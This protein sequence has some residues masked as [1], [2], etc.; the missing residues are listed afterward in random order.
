M[1]KNY[2]AG[3]F[4]K[5]H[6]GRSR[7]WLR[8]GPKFFWLIFANSTQ[9]SRVNKV[10]PYWPGSRACLRA[11]EALGFFITKYAF[12]TFWGTFLYYF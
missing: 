4:L 6:R 2:L 8:G 11:L 3:I 7:I 1:R 9:W 12:S 5:E 10:S